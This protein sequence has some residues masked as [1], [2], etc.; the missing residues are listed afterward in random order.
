MSCI[1]DFTKNLVTLLTSMFDVGSDVVNSLDFMGYNIS[2]TIV[3]TV[4][5]TK[6]TSSSG[7]VTNSMNSSEFNTDNTNSEYRVDNTWG[8]ISMVIVFMPGML[9]SIPMIAHSVCER[10]WGILI[11]AIVLSVT[12]PIAFLILQLAGL[13]F[14]GSSENSGGGYIIKLFVVLATGLEA[15]VESSCQLSL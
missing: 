11:V 13:F 5:G 4:T 10:N 8:V 3:D 6:E 15:S 7:K 2:S 9:A 14:C 12:F 1:I